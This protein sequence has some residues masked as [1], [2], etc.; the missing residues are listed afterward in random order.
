MIFRIRRAYNSYPRQFWLL[1]LVMMLAWSFHSMIWPFLILYTSQ[2]LNQPLT[3]VAGLLTLNSA[4]GLVTT[5]IGGAIA[6]RFG[7]KW[8]MAFSLIFCAV[9]WYSFRLAGTLPLFAILMALTGASTP[10]YRLAADAMIADVIPQENRIDAYSVMRLGNNLGVALGPAIG[11]FLAAISYNISFA[12]TGAGL[13]GCGLLIALFSIETIPQLTHKE[14]V[15]EKPVKGYLSALKDRNFV[16]MLGSFTFNRICSSIL[17]LLLAVYAKQNFGISERLFGFIPM[18]NAVMVILFQIIVTRWVKKRAPIPSMALGALF[19]AI[20][21]FAVAFGRG[22]WAFWFCM[23]I[24]TL[25][26]MI[27]LPTST[28]YVSRLAPENMRARYMSLY[29]LTWGIGTGL[30]PLFGGVLS[31]RV[32]PAAT[33]IGGGIAGLVGAFM[34]LI[35]ARNQ[36]KIEKNKNSLTPLAN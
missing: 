24:A 25:G 9:S 27:L 22:F 20:A 21:V 34:F 3:A 6:D 8:V 7:R 26:E 23:V 32:N 28:T 15:N 16:N 30:G 29:T 35:N 2:K 19:Y 17:W 1:A 12:I 18:T 13:F 11:G 14:I 5:F 36:K 10:L 33:W 4:T 31:D